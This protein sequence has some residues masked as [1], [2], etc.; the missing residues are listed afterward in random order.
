MRDVGFQVTRHCL[1]LLLP[2]DLGGA[3][4]E[5]I[6]AEILQAIASRR[7]VSA[8]VFDCTNLRLVDQQDM[9]CLVDLINCIKLMGKKV[10]LCSISA[11]MA[12]VL[13]SLNV[14][15]TGCIYGFNLDDAIGKL[16]V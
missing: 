6:R 16:Q 5:E 10:G 9:R 13:V 7:D 15:I 14:D 2:D 8:V 12:A 3:Y 1:T 4:L 11:G